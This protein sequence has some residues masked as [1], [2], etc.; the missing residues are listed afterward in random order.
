[1]FVMKLW[2]THLLLKRWKL[3]SKRNKVIGRRIKRNK[4]REVQH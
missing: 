4:E 3:K 1:M 2:L